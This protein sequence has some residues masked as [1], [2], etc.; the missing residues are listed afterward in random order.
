MAACRETLIPQLP[1]CHNPFSL[2]S[3]DFGLIF[4]FL[5]SRGRE[6]L[7]KSKLLSESL[8]FTCRHVVERGRKG[9][10]DKLNESVEIASK[11]SLYLSLFLSPSPDI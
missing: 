6:E 2:I 7:F 3:T 1:L 10:G 9:E 11:D 4:I 5:L 8:F